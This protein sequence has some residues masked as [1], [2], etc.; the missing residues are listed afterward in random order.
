MQ[1]ER[2]EGVRDART[3]QGTDDEVEGHRRDAAPQE[4]GARDA[5]SDQDE[6]E[7]EAHRFHAGPQEFGTRDA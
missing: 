6:D 1:E 4:P 3:D 2:E 5:L 7:V